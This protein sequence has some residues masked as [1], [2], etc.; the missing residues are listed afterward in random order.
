MLINLKL[1][2]K[3]QIKAFPKV[4]IFFTSSTSQALNIKYSRI[5]SQSLKNWIIKSHFI[6]AYFVV[7]QSLHEVHIYGFALHSDDKNKR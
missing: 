2:N 6:S 4:Y 5:C 7:R 3:Y 1:E